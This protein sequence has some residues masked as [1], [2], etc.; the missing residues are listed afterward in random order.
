MNKYIRPPKISVEPFR[1]LKIPTDLYVSIQSEYQSMSFTSLDQPPTYNK[2]YGAMAL[3]GISR[4]GSDKPD[5]GYSPVSANLIDQCYKVLSPMISNWCGHAVTRSWGYGIRS[6]GRNSILHLH[7]DRIDT[8]VISC[9]LHVDEHSDEP[10]P[11]D[12]IDHDGL[13]EK[14]FFE[15]GEALFYESLCPHARLTPFNGDYYRNMYLHWHPV[16]WNPEPFRAMKSTFTGLEDCLMTY[17]D[18]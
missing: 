16:D 1:K 4:Y 13:H 3:M 14:V 11:L 2:E 5:I 6:Y 18:E 12:F 17:R 9:I 10:W 8:H 15:P 7:R